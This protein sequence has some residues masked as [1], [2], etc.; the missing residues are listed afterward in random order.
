LDELAASGRNFRQKRGVGK[1][2]VKR[3][4]LYRTGERNLV[5]RLAPNAVISSEIRVSRYAML[6]PVDLNIGD[7][8]LPPMVCN[9]DVAAIIPVSG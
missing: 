7:A 8:L 6:S 9:F 5:M 3:P 2:G 1:G 4:N